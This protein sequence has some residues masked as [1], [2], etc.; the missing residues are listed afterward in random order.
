MLSSV[1]LDATEAEAENSPQA[2]T[3]ELAASGVQPVSEA[4]IERALLR[5]DSALGST[6][7]EVADPETRQVGRQVAA[8]TLSGDE[9]AA[10]TIARIRSG[11]HR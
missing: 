8:G 9:A 11:Q 10:R 2:D 4:Q 5:S 7:P 6:G 3:A 1:T